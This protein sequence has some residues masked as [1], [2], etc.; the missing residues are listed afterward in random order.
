MAETD[1]LMP[2]K[3][4]ALWRHILRNNFTNLDKLVGF[5]EFTSEQRQQLLVD[6]KFGLN[7]PLRLAQ[8]IVKGTFDDPILRQFVPTINESFVNPDFQLDPVDDQTFRKETKLLQKYAGRALLV[9]TSACAM[10]CRYCFR[11]NFTYDRQNRGFTKEIEMIRQDSSLNE[12]I[13]SGGDPLSLDN[14]VLDDLLNGLEN[15]P[16]VHRV[17]F[18]TRFPIGIPERIDEEFLTIL[19][20]RRVQL[21]FV[22]HVNHPHELDKDIFCSLKKLQTLGIP[23]LNQSVLLK[24]VNDTIET[25]KQLSECL[26]NH[27]IMPYYLH[28]LDQVQGASHF[29]VEQSQ[30]QNLIK[31][32]ST[33]LSGYAVP[34]YVKEIPGASSKTCL[35]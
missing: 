19:K 5:L 11:Q 7:L 17:R 25:Q 2:K 16:H 14:E 15:I 24:G 32:L 18:H 30:G 13:L 31:E 1:R 27:G 20:N 12:I 26:V 8:K 29:K 21:L 3:P 23:I 35:E 6:S 4:P 22:I 9:C 28:Q 10:H 33:V 34:K